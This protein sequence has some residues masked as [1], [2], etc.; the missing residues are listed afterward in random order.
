MYHIYGMGNALVDMEFE[1]S[2][3]FLKEF[4]IAKGGM[5]LVD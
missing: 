4:E 5:T 1:V 2:D 3:E